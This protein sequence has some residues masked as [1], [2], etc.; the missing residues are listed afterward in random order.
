MLQFDSEVAIYEHFGVKWMA[1]SMREDGTEFDKDLSEIVTLDDINGDIHMHTTASDGA[2]SLREMV[3]ANIEKG[4][5]F[6]YY[7]PFT[8]LTCGEWFVCG[9]FIETK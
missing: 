8:K 6:M 9:P 2:F 7:R 5:Q 3:E 4:Y 1:P